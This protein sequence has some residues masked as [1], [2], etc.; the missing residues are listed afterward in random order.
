MRSS[1]I[2]VSKIA[3]PSRIVRVGMIFLV[4]AIGSGKYLLAMAYRW[5]LSNLS[6]TTFDFLLKLSLLIALYC[7]GIYFYTYLRQTVRQK[8]MHEIQVSVLK[9]RIQGDLSWWEEQSGGKWQT[10]ISNDSVV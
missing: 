1:N 7:V 8:L 2:T 9:N 5:I 6:G 3:K 10:A 4:I